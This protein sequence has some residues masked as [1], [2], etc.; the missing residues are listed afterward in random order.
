MIISSL[1]GN[2][3]P[4]IFI[5]LPCLPTKAIEIW[6]YILQS[7]HVGNVPVIE[8]VTILHILQYV[9]YSYTTI[10]ALLKTLWETAGS[11]VLDFISCQ[12]AKDAERIKICKP[13]AVIYT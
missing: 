1:K 8:G 13:I 5:F 9:E 4:F 7:C 3:M 11:M 6:A 12:H 10:I 2:A